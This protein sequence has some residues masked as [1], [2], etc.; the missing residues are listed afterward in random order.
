MKKSCIV[1]LTAFVIKA[2]AQIY[3]GEKTSIRFF[4]ETKMENIEAINNKATPLLNTAN[5]N[6]AVKATQTDFVFKSSFM[7]E[8]YNENYMESEKYPQATFIGKI[9]ETID[10]KTNGT[11]T[12]TITGKLNMHGVEQPRTITGILTI[13]DGKI[14]MDAKFDVKVADHKIKV[15]SLYIEKIAEVIE[16]TYHSEM[17]PKK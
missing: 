9:N 17:I 16:V 8:H 12:V 3:T 1:L 15:P 2:Q 10:Y 13:K 7:Q 4:S 11:Y 14:N 5:G 6:F